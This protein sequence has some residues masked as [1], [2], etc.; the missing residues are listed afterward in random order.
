MKENQSI[1]DSLDI[2]ELREIFERWEAEGLIVQDSNAI[3]RICNL[4][5]SEPKIDMDNLL[6]IVESKVASRDN[7]L[8]GNVDLSPEGEVSIGLP[9]A[10]GY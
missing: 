9:E 8:A 10:A 7:V 5:V 1:I 4:S 3:K 2:E 6:V